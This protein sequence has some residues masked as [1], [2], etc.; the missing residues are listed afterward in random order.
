MNNP[1]PAIGLLCVFLGACESSS[2]RGPAAALPAAAAAPTS[3][4]E[5]RE[6]TG[7]WGQEQDGLQTRLSIAAGP[8]RIGAPLRLKLELRNIADAP[9]TYDPQQVDVNE[10]FFI[11]GPDGARVPWSGGWVQSCGHGLPIAP[12]ETKTLVADLDIS[13]TYVMTE[14]GLYRLVSR[15]HH[16]LGNHTIPPSAPLTVYLTAG[17]VSPADRLLAAIHRELPERWS[18]HKTPSGAA[19]GADHLD[20]YVSYNPPSHLKADVLTAG[21]VFGAEAPAKTETAP[22]LEYWGRHDLGQ[23]YLYFG[24]GTEAQWPGCRAALAAALTR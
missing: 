18:V 15:A 7:L 11:D 4:V 1:L 19:D 13:K 14:P 22:P 2:P 24:P 10:P 20:V 5:D 8:R 16:G 12:G 23:A 9:G 3:E 6:I 21:I 17:Q